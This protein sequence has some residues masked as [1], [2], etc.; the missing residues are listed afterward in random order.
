MTNSVENRLEE[1]ATR[2]DG[3]RAKPGRSATVTT[4]SSSYLLGKWR[5]SGADG[6]QG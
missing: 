2:A 4:S 5:V 3:T 1:D 6:G